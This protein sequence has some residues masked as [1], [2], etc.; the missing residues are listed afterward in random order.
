MLFK[1]KSIPTES[2]IPLEQQKVR[3]HEH[4][5]K[6]KRPRDLT[7]RKKEDKFSD[8]H[9]ETV[10]RFKAARTI[11]TTASLDAPVEKV[12]EMRE[13]LDLQE[14]SVNISDAENENENK[15][16]DQYLVKPP[17]NDELELIK[18]NQM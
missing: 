2:K 12:Q 13:M 18:N 9:G 7:L 4:G 15:I 16:F 6:P 10:E 11:K 8:R 17:T 5:P 1:K 14:E 3:C